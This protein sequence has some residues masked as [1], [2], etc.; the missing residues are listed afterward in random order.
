MIKLKLLE[1]LLQKTFI[2]SSISIETFYYT[3]TKISEKQIK[4][5]YRINI[6]DKN[7]T[8]QYTLNSYTFNYENN[9]YIVK[10]IIKFYKSDFEYFNKWRNKNEEKDDCTP[11]GD[12][13][14]SMP[15]HRLCEQEPDTTDRTVSTDK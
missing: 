14:A 2:K 13:T 12:S 8:Y 1:Y 5:V 9:I 3:Y 4:P 7:R 10:M 11:S 15:I 6:Y